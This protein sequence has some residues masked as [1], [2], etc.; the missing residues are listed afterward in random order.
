MAILA[1]ASGHPRVLGEGAFGQAR[2]QPL[3]QRRPQ[4]ALRLCTRAALRQQPGRQGTAVLCAS[5]AAY[6]TRGRQ[7]GL[8]PVV[9]V[10][11]VSKRCHLDLHYYLGP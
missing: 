1:D 2:A 3:L 4:I 8:L 10:Q 7:S 9:L 11:W 6:V 5:N